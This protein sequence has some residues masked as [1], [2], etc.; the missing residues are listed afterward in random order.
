MK[1]TQNNKNIGQ[2]IFAIFQSYDDVEA[3]ID[4]LER[5]GFDR[6][7]ISMLGNAE[8][9]RKKLGTNYYEINQILKHPKIPK[10][11]YISTESIRVGEGGVVSII[12]YFTSITT[13]IILASFKFN[14]VNIVAITIIACGIGAVIGMFIAERLTMGHFKELEHQLNHGGI[15][16]WVKTENET[17]RQ[18]AEKILHKYCG[19]ETGTQKN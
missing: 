4:E 18:K 19:V 12:M 14:V 10:T 17:Y 15:V 6:A 9:I 13:A 16:I 8:S 2:E 11:F 3:A 7:T 1:K 5:N